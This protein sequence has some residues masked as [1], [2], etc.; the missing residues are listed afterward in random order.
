MAHNHNLIGH[1][2]VP[3]LRAT[4]QQTKCLPRMAA[5]VT[6]AAQD[7]VHCV[8]N[9]A[10]FRGNASPQKIFPVSEPPE[11]VAIGIQG[12]LPKIQ[13]GYKYIIRIADLFIKLVQQVP[14][15]RIRSTD[16]TKAY[17]EH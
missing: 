4:L 14:L 9:R 5:D 17:M 10:R 11:L 13:R 15:G 8:E 2:G 12:P 3:Q 7:C 1:P 16:V 6:S